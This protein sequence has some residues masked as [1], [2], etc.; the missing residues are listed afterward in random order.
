MHSTFFQDYYKNTENYNHPAN[1]PAL[2]TEWTMCLESAQ[3]LQHLNDKMESWL[4]A[5]GSQ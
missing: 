3:Q 1:G 2:I 5:Q 4:T